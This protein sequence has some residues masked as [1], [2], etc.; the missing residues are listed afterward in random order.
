[1]HQSWSKITI[2]PGFT[3]Y[4]LQGYSYVV[5]YLTLLRTEYAVCSIGKC[6]PSIIEETAREYFS[7]VS[8]VE[9]QVTN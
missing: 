9:V 8:T 3:F 6:F 2:C 7:V 5:E 1:M 4:Y